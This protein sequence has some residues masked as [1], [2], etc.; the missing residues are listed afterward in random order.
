MRSE[1]KLQRLQELLTDEILSELGSEQHEIMAPSD[2][3][4][5]RGILRD[6]SHL[7]PQS[8]KER[9]P[10]DTLPGQYAVGGM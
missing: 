5:V 10:D 2:R 8:T 7:I 3:D 6:F 9:F 4:E 1:Q